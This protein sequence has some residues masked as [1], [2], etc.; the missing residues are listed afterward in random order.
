[1][2]FHLRE[3]AATAAMLIATG[4][5]GGDTVISGEIFVPGSGEVA[6]SS[7]LAL[8]FDRAARAH[9][10]PVDLLK[11]LAY[12]QTSVE[13]AAGAVEFEGQEPAY[14]FFALR[15]EEL[16]RA[17]RLAGYSRD[18]LLGDPDKDLEAG[19]ALLASYADELGIEPALRVDP[20]VWKPAIAR[21]GGLAE[22]LRE[23]FAEDVLRHLA[24]VALPMP[25][26]TT[27]VI[28]RY[29]QGTTEESGKG[30]GQSGSV[31]RA[32]GNYG[33]GRNGNT[34]HLVI[35][36]TCEGGYWGCVDWLRQPVSGVSAHY[37][38]KE[39]GS[40]ISQLVDENN[41]AWHV[42]QSYRDWLNG[43]SHPDLQGIPVNLV[44]VGIEHGGFAAQSSWPQGQI[45]ASVELVRGITAR[46]NIPRD[47][48]HIVAHGRLQP[49]IRV[50]PGPNWPWTSYLAA[51]ARDSTP[52]PA[53]PP[54]SPPPANPPAPSSAAVLTVDNTTDGRFRASA[55]W[56]TSSWAA[57]R[58]GSNY[59]YRGPQRISD[60]ADYKFKITT[61]G[62]YQ[63]YARVPGNGYNTRVPYVIHHR[64]GRAVVW[65]DISNRGAAWV[66][67]GTY[68][69]DAIDDWIVQISVWTD[70]EGW[71]IADAVK[72]EP[73]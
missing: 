25:D 31:W 71:V 9:G 65:R 68:A 73:R 70:N 63:V 12:H 62:N 56:Q 60:S 3:Y 30:L 10:V 29:R 40:E 51:I 4:C 38:V 28:R 69:F 55:N 47:R 36:H 1:M 59:R 5:T 35:I 50:D 18:D 58:V 22:D 6:E 11:A 72:L 34:P 43:N 8:S 39:D 17:A 49:E 26:G 24:G 15:G 14:G 45:D 44:A 54:A 57:G 37:V 20:E 27:F 64:D 23:E 67:L 32:S 19:A 52:P 46:W 33:W 21:F 2:K 16:D 7:P 41:T 53:A 48:Y 42:G 61:P 66:N 13:A